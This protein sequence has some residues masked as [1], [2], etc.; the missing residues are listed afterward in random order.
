MKSI[1]LLII[2][3][4]LTFLTLI[5]IAPVMATPSA[6]VQHLQ[7]NN[8]FTIAHMRKFSTKNSINFSTGLVLT[9]ASILTEDAT[10]TTLTAVETSNDFFTSV[11]IMSDKIHQLFS[12][13]NSLAKGIFLS[14]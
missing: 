5:T 13:F 4:T 2:S 14:K 3:F 11:M 10:N 9:S 12:Y 8:M 7:V 1:K 6:K